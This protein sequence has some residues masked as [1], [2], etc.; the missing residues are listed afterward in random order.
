MKP[1]GLVSCGVIPIVSD[2][3]AG[4]MARAKRRGPASRMHRGLLGRRC[5]ARPPA[6]YPAPG[7]PSARRGAVW[8]A[9]AGGAAGDQDRDCPRPTYSG[10]RSSLGRGA[11]H[12]TRS[13]SRREPRLCL[14]GPGV[15]P[16]YAGGRGARPRR[17]ADDGTI[18][19]WHL[20]MWHGPSDGPSWARASP[21]VD[22]AS[23]G[24][25]RP[26]RFPWGAAPRAGAV[27]GLE[28]LLAVLSILP[29]SMAHGLSVLF[30]LS[31]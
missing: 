2:P 20:A 29:C 8:L 3:G 5:H 14:K 10:P 4:R 31:Y 1:R 19:R 21:W 24:R 6:I 16:P 28:P 9:V 30:P 27:P 18:F 7:D 23:G 22:D 13:R 25:H 26:G 17:R 15:F 11:G 12:Q